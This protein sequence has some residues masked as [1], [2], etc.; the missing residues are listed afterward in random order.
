[1]VSQLES[2]R[3]NWSDTLGLSELSDTELLNQLLTYLDSYKNCFSHPSQFRYFSTFEKGL[4]SDLDR[5][6]IEPIALAFLGESSVRSLQQFFTRSTGF[7][8]SL[9]RSYHQQLSDT[10]SAPDGFLCVDG[11]FIKKGN[12]SAGV[13]RQ[14]CGRLRKTEN[15]QAGIFSSYVSEKGYGLIDSQL[16]LPKQWVSDDY[17]AK[18]KDCRIPDDTCFQ[19][20]NDLALELIQ[21]AVASN[22]FDIKWIGCDHA[23]LRGLPDS[24]YYFAAVKEDERLYLERPTMSIPDN[25]KKKGRPFKQSLPDQSPVTVKEIALSDDYSWER[26]LIAEGAKGPIYA[27]IKVIKAV[28]CRS[29]TRYGNYL[30]PEEDVWVYIRRYDDGKFNYFLSNATMNTPIE[31]LDQLAT[32]RWSIEQCFQECKSYLGMTHYETRTCTAW[33]RHMLCV[34][35]A[36]LFTTI[37]RLGYKKNSF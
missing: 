31:T 3:S 33:Y 24:I 2:Y 35:I 5:K 1:M 37:F 12:N 8:E 20:K 11:N 14:Y 29:T 18:R 13:A 4:L 34:M 19:T 28:A 17:V 36:H 26:K 22:D 23:F 10:L 21:Q 6:S 7:E 16:Y 9:R 27:D 32:K 15:C 25:L 30:A